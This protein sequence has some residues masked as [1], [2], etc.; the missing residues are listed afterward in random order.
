[1][2]DYT[3]AGRITG[4]LPNEGAAYVEGVCWM[5]DERGNPVKPM[6]GETKLVQAR[7]QG[8][9]N[10]DNWMTIV[11]GPHPGYENWTQGYWS[12]T[13]AQLNGKWELRALDDFRGIVSPWVLVELDSFHGR[14]AQMV[15]EWRPVAAQPEP[16]PTP[17][18][19]AQA[20]RNA[21]WQQL[22]IPYNPDAALTKYAREHGLGNPVTAEDDTEGWR[23]QGFMG[24]IVRCPI[25]QWNKVEVLPW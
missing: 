2:T 10:S 6:S 12:F 9:A 18:D 8:E 14:Q 3:I 23:W 22:G 16:E 4:I 1:M 20:I 24:G 17:T 13:P 15:F 25:G 5:L 7:W 19:P 11:T 21:A